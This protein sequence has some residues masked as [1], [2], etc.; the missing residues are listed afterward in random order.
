MAA[1]TPMRESAPK[2]VSRRHEPNGI[3]QGAQGRQGWRIQSRSNPAAVGLGRSSTL[4]ACD[5]SPVRQRGRTHAKAPSNLLLAGLAAFTGPKN[6]LASI[7]P[8]GSGH[9]GLPRR[10]PLNA[11]PTSPDANPAQI[12]SSSLT[13][14]LGTLQLQVRIVEFVLEHLL[15]DQRSDLARLSA[16]YSAV[17]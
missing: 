9:S 15:L 4:L 11:N 17:L 6:T 8:V 16:F 3:H 7:H 10:M 12:R 1:T 2:T 5:P 13:R 14:L